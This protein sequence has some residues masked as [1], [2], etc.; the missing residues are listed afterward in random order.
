MPA[1]PNVPEIAIV[2]PTPGGSHLGV[3]L[4]TG[5]QRGDV[6]TKAGRA[7]LAGAQTY[8]GSLGELI[9]T[10]WTQR[11]QLVFILAVGAVVRTNRP[12]SPA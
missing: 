5:L 3:S 2:A 1:I 6:W 11:R 12:I 7:P 4:A 8:D 9:E 10:L